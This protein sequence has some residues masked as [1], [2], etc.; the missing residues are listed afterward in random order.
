M[1]LNEHEMLLSILASNKAVGE[2]LDHAGFS[3][4]H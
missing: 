2:V 1:V 4:S 3:V